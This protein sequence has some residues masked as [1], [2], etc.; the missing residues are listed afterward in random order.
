MSKDVWWNR[1]KTEEEAE[2]AKDRGTYQIWATIVDHVVNHGLQWLKGAAK[3]WE[4]DHILNNSNISKKSLSI[5]I[6]H[7]VMC[8]C[9]LL[10]WIYGIPKKRCCLNFSTVTVI[11]T[12][13]INYSLHQVIL[14][15]CSVILTT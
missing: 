1:S 4:I 6:P 12:V 14:T 3:Y 2:E 13:S 15:V 9:V 5:N 10:K 8:K 7:T 11:Q